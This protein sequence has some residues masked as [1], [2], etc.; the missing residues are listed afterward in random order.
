MVPVRKIFF[1]KKNSLLI[2]IIKSNFS[3]TKHR[4]F[5]QF[6]MYLTLKKKKSILQEKS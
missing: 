2:S 4:L 1:K 5:K 3:V 6:N